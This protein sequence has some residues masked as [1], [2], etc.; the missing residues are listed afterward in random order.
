MGGKSKSSSSSSSKTNQTTEQIQIHLGDSVITQDLSGFLGKPSIIIGSSVTGK[1]LTNTSNNNKRGDFNPKAGNEAS[2]SNDSS[3]S[4]RAD[5]MRASLGLGLQTPFSN[6]GIVKDLT[7]AGGG[8]GGG[9]N[10]GN[11]GGY[12][13]GDNIGDVT[14]NTGGAT[15]GTSGF[16][17]RSVLNSD[18]SD[19]MIKIVAIG[20]AGA[21]GIA[22]LAKGKG[23]K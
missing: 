13:G 18:N 7:G 19:N 23:K 2:S 21:L 1:T 6:E 5:G 14:S 22:L 12:A 15:S 3:S 8:S 17:S 4:A 10:G 16:I 9:S 11:S 20:A